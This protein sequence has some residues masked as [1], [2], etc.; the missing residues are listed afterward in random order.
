MNELFSIKAIAFWFV[1]PVF[2]AFLLNDINYRSLQESIDGTG[3]MLDLLSCG[4][5]IF[6]QCV[7]IA[8]LKVIVLAYGS[9]F[10]LVFTSLAGIALFYVSSFAAEV[11]FPFGDMKNVLSMQ[12]RSVSYWGSILAC[13]GLIMLLELIFDRYHR[14]IDREL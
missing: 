11:I 6:V 10:G 12:L 13:V 8:N 5:N 14:L 3:F 7:I 4:M 1:S 2:Y 9:S